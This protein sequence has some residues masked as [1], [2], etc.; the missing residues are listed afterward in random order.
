MVKFQIRS[1]RIPAFFDGLPLSDLPG[2]LEAVPSGGPPTC[3]LEQSFVKK[4]G[5]S[6]TNTREWDGGGNNYYTF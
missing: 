5:C 6:M 1:G 4:S 3:S 2:F